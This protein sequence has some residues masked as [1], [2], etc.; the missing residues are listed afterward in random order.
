MQNDLLYAL[1]SKE[2]DLYNALAIAREEHK[3]LANE[4]LR[5]KGT[6]E[7][8]ELALYTKGDE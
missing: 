3:A 1:R 4:Y 5:V 8:L 6:R 7:K 2:Q